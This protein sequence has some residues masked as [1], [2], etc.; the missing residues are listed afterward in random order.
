MCLHRVF[1][2]RKLLSDLPVAQPLANAL[3]DLLFPVGDA[4]DLP[5]PGDGS[6]LLEQ[7]PE[8]LVVLRPY[9]CLPDLGQ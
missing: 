4:T 5:W 2:E 9:P 7:G 6:G 1:R 3:D 8:R